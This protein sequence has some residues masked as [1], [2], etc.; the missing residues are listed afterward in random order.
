MIA[1]GELPV[2]EVTSSL[3]QPSAAR[4]AGRIEMIVE[5]LALYIGV[6][7]PT[8]P[9][10][11]RLASVAMVTLTADDHAEEGDEDQEQ[12]PAP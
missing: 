6:S 1:V 7:G 10:Q 2:G 9:D 4:A 11:L 12:V 5:L 8:R 3:R